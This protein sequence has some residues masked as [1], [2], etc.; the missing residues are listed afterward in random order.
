MKLERSFE[1]KASLDFESLEGLDEFKAE[2]YRGLLVMGKKNVRQE[3]RHL[4]SE[5]KPY[6]G[7]CYVVTELLYHLSDKKITPKVLPTPE[8]KHWYIQL[9]DGTPLDL[10]SDREYDYTAGVKR[11][12]MTQAMSARTKQLKEIMGL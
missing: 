12:F 7:Y 2:L 9:S 4:W 1:R 8:G 10:T 5:D 11:S 3:Y 6:I